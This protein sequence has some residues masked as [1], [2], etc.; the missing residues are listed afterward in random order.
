MTTH[1][2]TTVDGAAWESLS[3]TISPNFDK[4]S[5]A[6]GV[7]TKPETLRILVRQ[8]FQTATTRLGRSDM[9]LPSLRAFDVNGLDYRACEALLTGEVDGY[10]SAGT[11]GLHEWLDAVTD[12]E[13]ICVVLNE[14]SSWDADLGEVL[15]RDLATPLLE[16]GANLDRGIDWYCFA[17]S[18]GPTPF[19]VHCDAEPSL[20]FN[21][22]PAVKTAYVWPV[23]AL[24]TL[25]NG[26]A[27][28]LDYVE[29]LEFAD[30]YRLAPGDFLLVP[31]D[32]YHVFRNEGPSLLLGLSIFPPDPIAAVLE[33]AEAELR[34][35]Y[36]G[37]V[38]AITTPDVLDRLRGLLAT[39]AVERRIEDSIAA[40]R[41]S[42]YTRAPRLRLRED[43]ALPPYRVTSLP[44]VSTSD[45]RI[46]ACGR[47]FTASLDGLGDLLTPGKLVSQDIITSTVG[48]RPDA[49]SILRAL[50]RAGALRSERQDL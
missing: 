35:E 45:G 16:A 12:R 21:L 37:S 8:A 3:K 43:D 18:T 36:A 33:A 14:L 17:A 15:F 42:G 40:R 5:H 32:R 23:D 47:S 22:G 1:H 10:P 11:A 4:V 6:V 2:E 44:I 50:H 46:H 27:R 20:L 29:L 31:K 34:R 48:A 49:H 24:P 9:D 39:S 25:P 41:S 7:V 13:G 26:R 30:R 28:T 38:P 19:G